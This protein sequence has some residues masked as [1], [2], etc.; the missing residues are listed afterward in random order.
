MNPFGQSSRSTCESNDEGAAPAA[1]MT[2]SYPID[3]CVSSVNCVC[4]VKVVIVNA[5]NEERFC[6]VIHKPDRSKLRSIR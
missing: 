3:V 4:V 1:Q 6:S 2:Q 5:I